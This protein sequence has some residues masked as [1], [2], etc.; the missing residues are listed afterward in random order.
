M[1]ELST[2]FHVKGHDSQP[3][4]GAMHFRPAPLLPEGKV[5]QRG[6]KHVRDSA[7]GGS[8][9]TGGILPLTYRAEMPENVTGK[10]GVVAAG[11]ASAE[12]DQAVL[13]TTRPLSA[14][15]G[16]ALKIGLAGATAQ[17]AQDREEPS[18]LI[19]SNRH[20]DLTRVVSPRGTVSR[21]S[22]YPRL[23]R[24][25]EAARDSVARR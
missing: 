14:S 1:Q 6:T 23:P 22:S 10:R 11:G 8:R 25:S 19:Y 21:P 12:I 20:A 15:A 16:A 3:D 18:T 5:R 17:S 9:L 7:S 13:L 4:A 2:R 24:S